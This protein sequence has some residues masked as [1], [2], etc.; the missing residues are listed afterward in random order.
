MAV[1]EQ[2]QETEPEEGYI[3]LD[4]RVAILQTADMA[5]EEKQAAFSSIVHEFTPCVRGSASRILS[6]EVDIEDVTQSTFLRAWI[7]IDQYRPR[8][9]FGGWLAVISHNQAADLYRRRHRGPHEF[10]ETEKTITDTMLGDGTL[11]DPNLDPEEVYFG[12]TIHQERL[13]GLLA[14]IEPEFAAPL[15]L[16]AQDLSYD[17]IAERLNIPVGTVRSRIHRGKVKIRSTVNNS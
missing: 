4:P 13:A 1:V 14:D 12:R 11:A 5:T 7:K 9:P 16:L 6:S 17:Q 2:Y 10:G 15:A 8:R 3:E